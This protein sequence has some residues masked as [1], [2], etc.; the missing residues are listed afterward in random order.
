LGDDALCLLAK[1]TGFSLRES[2]LSPEIFFDLLFFASSLSHNSSLEQLVS[3]TGFH[4]LR[5]KD[6]TTF[7]VPDH[8]ASH[9]G[10]NGGGAAGI[11]IQYE[12]DLKTGQFLDLTITEACRKRTFDEQPFSG[13]F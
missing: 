11:T 13:R 8:L 10:G 7:K 2:Q 3:Q 5:I 4:H 12:F 9:Y 6:S 1:E